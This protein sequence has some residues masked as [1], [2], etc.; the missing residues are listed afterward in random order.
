MARRRLANPDRFASN[1]ISGC[2]RA[3]KDLLP[4]DVYDVA[5]GLSANDFGVFQVSAEAIRAEGFP[6]LLD[7]NLAPLERVVRALVL[8]EKSGQWLSWTDRK[9]GLKWAIFPR[10]GDEQTAGNPTP[11]RDPYPP[12]RILAKCSLKTREFFAKYSREITDEFATDSR[13]TTTSL[14]EEDIKAL[15]EGGKGVQGEGSGLDPEL[16]SLMQQLHSVTGYPAD[17]AKDADMLQRAV[18][19]YGMALVRHVVGSWVLR[20]QD[21]P[22]RPKAR[23]RVELWNWFRIQK[24]WDGERRPREG[25][26][27]SAAR[28]WPRN[29]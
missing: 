16:L 27:V 19:L 1:T 10:W 13:K 3:M 20:R 21:D 2:C 8:L 4:R 23:P 18:G 29:G 12:D 26:T 17:P 25:Q 22:L 28:G 11:S 6:R 24:G 9:S 15:E 14:R 5:W 7:T